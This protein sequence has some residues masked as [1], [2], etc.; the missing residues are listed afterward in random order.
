MW[1]YDIE[2]ISKVRGRTGAARSATHRALYVLPDQGLA[3]LPRTNADAEKAKAA[4]LQIQLD[5]TEPN[6]GNVYL[7]GMHAVRMPVKASIR[8]SSSPALLDRTIY[9]RVLESHVR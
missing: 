8:P 9:T 4:A 1:R 5:S 2:E 6:H 3:R 7:D